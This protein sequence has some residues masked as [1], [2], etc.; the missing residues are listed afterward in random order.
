M[1]VLLSIK[2]DYVE[3]ILTGKKRYEL[4]KRI[5]KRQD[6]DKVILYSTAP[7]K[8]IVGHFTIGNIIMDSPKNLWR[9]VG[10]ESGVSFND[11]FDYFNGFD[12]GYA[13]EIRDL[14][15]YES[16]IDPWS[17]DPFFIAPQSFRYVSE[18]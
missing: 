10:G 12:R 6:V 8:M 11:F 2:P 5:F 4:R 3:A 7:T 1:N 9:I 13:I 16:P 14:V 18:F 15:K 17:H